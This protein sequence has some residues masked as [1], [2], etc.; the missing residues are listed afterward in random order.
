MAKSDRDR[1]VRF[2]S[3]LVQLTQDKKIQWETSSSADRGFIAKINARQVRLY[4]Y[5][6]EIPNPA[7]AQYADPY[8]IYSTSTITIGG[9]FNQQRPE[10]PKTIITSGVILE[11]YDNAGRPAYKFD[12]T[13][14]LY[15]LYESASYSAAKVDELIDSV[16]GKE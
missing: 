13:T 3:K 10:P 12:S 1:T 7:Y 15:D 9:L 2:I 11:V 5:S 14:G 8:S 16:L 4:K 6:E